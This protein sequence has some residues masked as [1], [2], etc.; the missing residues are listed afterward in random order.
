M[1]GRVPLQVDELGFAT[2]A[3][4]VHSPNQDSR[5]AG[6]SISLLVVHGISLPPGSFGGGAI[7]SFFCNR[8]D[9]AGHPYFREIS[10]LRVSAHFLI[11]RDGALTQFVSCNRRAWHAGVS[12]W[13]GRGRCNDFSIGVELEGL[14]ELGYDPRQYDCLARLTLGLRDRYPVTDIAGHSDIA[15]GRKSDPGPAFDWARF[16]ELLSRGRDRLHF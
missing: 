14:D 16:N 10:D 4:L 2:N 12:Q 6:E 9:P 11:A 7:Q 8:L 1:M 5:P 15:P 3:V 13:R